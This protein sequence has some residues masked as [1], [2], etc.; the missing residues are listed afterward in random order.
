VLATGGWRYHVSFKGRSVEGL[1]SNPRR[2][3][4]GTWRASFG[5]TLA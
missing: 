5:L 2:D 3:V 1:V 4:D